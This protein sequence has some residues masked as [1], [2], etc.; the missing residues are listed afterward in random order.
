MREWLGACLLV[1]AG[2]EL[3]FHPST[4]DEGFVVMRLG[5]S[6]LAEMHMKELGWTTTSGQ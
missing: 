5:S 3:G 1:A 2:L 6:R 4:H